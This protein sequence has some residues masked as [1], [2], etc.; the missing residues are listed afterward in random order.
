LKDAGQNEVS[1]R[2]HLEGKTAE[3]DA[4]WQSLDNTYVKLKICIENPIVPI[5]LEPELGL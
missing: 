3:E 2:I 5:L 4:I 1:S